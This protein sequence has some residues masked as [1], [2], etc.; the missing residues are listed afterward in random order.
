MTEFKKVT[1]LSLEVEALANAIMADTAAFAASDGTAAAA[2]ASSNSDDDS[3]GG[4]SRW[5]PA[6][7]KQLYEL[8]EKYRADSD[9]LRQRTD[10]LLA[11][12]RETDPNLQTY[13]EATCAKIEALGVEVDRILAIVTDAEPRLAAVEAAYFSDLRQQQA[14]QAAAEAT[15][16][17]LGALQQQEHEHRLVMQDDAR[18]SRAELLE[19]ES[20]G[21]K[22]V[23]RAEADRA[24][25]AWAA[26]QDR[27]RAELDAARAVTA[28]ASRGA[29][30]FVNGTF[31]PQ[32]LEGLPAAARAFLLARLR[33]VVGALCRDPE[34][35]GLRTMRT[36]SERFTK[37]FGHLCMFGAGGNSGGGGG[38]PV[39]AD[40]AEGDPATVER[41]L[42]AAAEAI[43]FAIGY[44]PTYTASPA[45]FWL[46]V[47]AAAGAATS[48]KCDAT[49]QL[50]TLHAKLIPWMQYGDRRLALIEPPVAEQPDQW[51]AWHE[52]LKAVNEALQKVK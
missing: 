12:A 43:F 8:S 4:G 24:A 19:R 31:V 11:K 50:V 39:G 37:A 23:Y 35:E 47:A 26:E 16:A 25:R 44:E 7:P 27:R 48:F 30:E 18:R 34:Q 13:N 17:S 46:E 1:A 29:A 41:Q 6:H 51:I 32:R 28:A 38:V 36:D 33:E 45:Q 5:A 42:A 3:N 21:R 20:A 52:T 49:G 22:A 40:Q 9:A 2:A 15:V 14:H 10:K